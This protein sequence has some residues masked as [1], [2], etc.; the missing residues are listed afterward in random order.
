M[1]STRQAHQRLG[2]WGFTQRVMILSKYQDS[3]QPESKQALSINQTVCSNSLG[4]V[5]YTYQIP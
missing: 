3:S 1:P 4:A 2:A 5:S